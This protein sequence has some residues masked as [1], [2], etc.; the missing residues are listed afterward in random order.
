M[1]AT[2]KLLLEQG[3]GGFNF[4]ALSIL[5]D[6]GRSTLYEYYDSK[7]DLIVAYMNELMI[8]YTDELAEIVLEENAKLQLLQLIE[9]MIKYAHIHSI[10]K[11][12]PLL[13]SNSPVVEEMKLNF[14]TDHIHIIREIEIVIDHGKQ[15]NVIR[16][17]IPTNVLVNLLFNTI[18]KPVSLK[19]DNKAWAKWIW[20]IIYTG[21]KV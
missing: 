19:I 4:S 6:I 14:I 17:E 13:K 7:D 8:S 15:E 18:N 12:I 9:L 16:E 20:E 21:M 1:K 5:L 10:L 3:Y 11:M 2:E